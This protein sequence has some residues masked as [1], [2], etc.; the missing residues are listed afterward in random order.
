[1]LTNPQH[2][3]KRDEWCCKAAD[4]TR[5]HYPLLDGNWAVQLC[6][7]KDGVPA[8]DRVAQVISAVANHA[9]VKSYLALYVVSDIKTTIQILNETQ[10]KMRRERQVIIICLSQKSRAKLCYIF[11]PTATAFFRC[12]KTGEKGWAEKLASKELKHKEV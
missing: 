8:Q 6:D 12:G 5:H 1:M 11:L 9:L 3:H 4:V 2:S 10:S 7:I